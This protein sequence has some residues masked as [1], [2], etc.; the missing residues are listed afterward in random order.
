MKRMDGRSRE[1]E[2][3]FIQA[4]AEGVKK[5]ALCWGISS[6]RITLSSR[7]VIDTSAASGGPEGKTSPPPSLHPSLPP[8]IPPSVRCFLSSAGPSAA[9][10][11]ADSD[12]ER[13]QTPQTPRGRRGALSETAEG[14]PTRPPIT[15]QEMEIKCVAAVRDIIYLKL[16]KT[17]NFVFFVTGNDTFVWGQS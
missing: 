9:C 13:P 6:V 16:V 3:K 10:P 8:S 5:E 1:K 17:F 11:G 4:G 2:G 12:G 15:G 14:V 7:R